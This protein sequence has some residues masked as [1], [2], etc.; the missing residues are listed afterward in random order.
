MEGIEN[1]VDGNYKYREAGGEEMLRGYREFLENCGVSRIIRDEV[2]RFHVGVCDASIFKIMEQVRRRQLYFHIYHDT[3][4]MNE[5]K[6]AALYSFWILKLQP[7]YWKGE[8]E[9]KP[10]YELNA[11]IALRIFTRGLT[12]YAA[13]KTVEAQKEG[14]HKTYAANLKDKAALDRLEYSFCFRDLS[15]EAMM[16]LAESMIIEEYG[17]GLCG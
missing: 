11:K 16:D 12:C 14:L 17:A 9:E 15:K 10:G 4:G 6:E 8:C 3:E 5:L 1:F 7:F 2:E 13:D